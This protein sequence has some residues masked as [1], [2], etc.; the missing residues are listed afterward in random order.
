M[1][2]GAVGWWSSDPAGLGCSWDRCA[3]AG[4]SGG[5]GTR[6]FLK[7]RQRKMYQPWG[8]QTH[9]FLLIF[10]IFF[11]RFSNQDW[12]LVMLLNIF[13]DICW[14]LS[15]S[16]NQKCLAAACFGVW[17]ILKTDREH[18]LLQTTRKETF[19]Q[20]FGSSWSFAPAV[21]SDPR[22]W[23]VGAVLT[24]QSSAADPTTV[25]FWGWKQEQ[26]QLGWWPCHCAAHRQQ[27]HFQLGLGCLVDSLVSDKGCAH[28][29]AP[30]VCRGSACALQGTGS[31]SS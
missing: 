9:P 14:Y 24:S 18:L 21:C 17:M 12:R 4:W 16:H 11:T 23:R 30:I 22:A 27:E 2:A 1:G 6:Y 20:K 5:F 28:L 8:L 26:A 7:D 31:A 3:T 13:V 25:G 29:A 19:G 15:F 10:R